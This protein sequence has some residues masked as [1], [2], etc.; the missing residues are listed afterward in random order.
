MNICMLTTSFPRYEGDPAGHFVCELATELSKKHEI[1][2][3]APGMEGLN[4]YESVGKLKVFRF[5]YFFPYK[6]EKVAYGNGIIKNLEKK[7]S[8]KALLPLFA[9][10]FLLKS[11]KVG[12]QCDLIHAHWA[13]SGLIAL[14]GKK[15]HKKPVI[16]SVRGS[17]INARFAGGKTSKLALQWVLRRCDYITTVSDNL[18]RKVTE[19][20]GIDQKIAVIPNGVSLESFYPI[21]RSEVR[22]KLGLPDD[23][24]IVLYAGRII[25]SKGIESL[26]EA[27]PTVLKEYKET[28]FIFLGEGNLVEKTF[29]LCK[30]MG[31]ERNILFTGRK[32]H[33]EMALWL[34]TADLIVLPSL[35]EGRPNIILEAMACGIPVVATRVGG[36]PEL[37]REGDNGFLVPPNDASALGRAILTVLKMETQKDVLGE[38]GRAI[39]ESAG[40]SWE[41]SAEKMTEIY[42][43]VLARGC[44]SLL[45]GS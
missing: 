25:E 31:V 11:I 16:L 20:F 43:M 3:V 27:I 29:D 13:F 42:R 6:Y 33:S 28:L 38:R 45:E 24:P 9:L 2:V 7:S 34:N 30:E 17:D 41:T 4:S 22:G 19:R 10:S 36:I 32:P 23:I 8:Y 35:S 12:S 44:H 5:H 21:D 15:I 40:L 1:M 14:W 39:L 37:V 26:V 18:L